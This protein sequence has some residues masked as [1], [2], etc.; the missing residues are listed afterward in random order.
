M[1]LFASN[2]F[3]WS[4]RFNASEL[5]RI[6]GSESGYA[7]TMADARQRAGEAAGRMAIALAEFVRDETTYPAQREHRYD[8]FVLI[9][10]I[11]R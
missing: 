11:R 9:D 1:S 7:S 10:E 2:G 8:V 6:V 3:Y 5:A 4:V